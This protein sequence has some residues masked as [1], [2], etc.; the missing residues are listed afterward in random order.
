MTAPRS[1]TAVGSLALELERVREQL[2]ILRESCCRELSS[3]DAAAL[4][5][6]LDS[7]RR[8]LDGC[9]PRERSGDRRVQQRRS[10][11][12]IPAR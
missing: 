1:D 2:S 9:E 8:V 6:A 4:Q 3:E 12:P 10:A 7:I 11:L 5:D